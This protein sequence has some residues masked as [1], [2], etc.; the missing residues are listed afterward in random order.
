M[1]EQAPQWAHCPTSACNFLQVC[2]L[3]DPQYTSA[4]AAAVEAP[5]ELAGLL[6]EQDLRR[7]VQVRLRAGTVPFLLPSRIIAWGGGYVHASW[8]ALMRAEVGFF[9]GLHDDPTHRGLPRLSD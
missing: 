2:V 8:P 7:L 6:P 1:H 4:A 3:I 5:E 9:K